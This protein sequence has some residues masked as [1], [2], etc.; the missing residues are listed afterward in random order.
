M[1]T[2]PVLCISRSNADYKVEPNLGEHVTN[3]I[4]RTRLQH[5]IF[6]GVRWRVRIDARRFSANV[7]EVLLAKDGMNLAQRNVNSN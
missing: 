5:N 7:A 2:Q 1:S 3:A 6:L 4:I